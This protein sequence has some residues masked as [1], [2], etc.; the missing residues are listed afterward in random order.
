MEIPYQNLGARHMWVAYQPEFDDSGRV[1]GFVA[2]ILDIT[3]RKRIENALRE[4]EERIAKAFEL[5]PL[6]Q[7][8]ISLRT[9][10]LVEVNETFVRLSG[11]TREE[12]IGRTSL[13]LGL[14]ARPEDREAELA[15]VTE[16]GRVQDAEYHFRNKDGAILVGLLSAERLDIGGEPCVLS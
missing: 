12:A 10:R 3:E 11:Y 1:T 2:A 9:G 13:E 15:M 4:S 16:R 14:W 5:S 7:T 8:I 6:A